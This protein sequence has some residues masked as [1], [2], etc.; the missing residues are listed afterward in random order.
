MKLLKKILP[1]ML[2]IALG[3]FFGYIRYPYVN[4]KGFVFGVLF[5]SI[6]LLVYRLSSSF[7]RLNRKGPK[8]IPLLY[9]L[10]AIVICYLAFSNKR[11]RN[12]N[13]KLQSEIITEVEEQKTENIEA[14]RSM[15]RLCI[16]QAKKEIEQHPERKL[17]SERIKEIIAI[18]RMIPVRSD[19]MGKGKAFPKSSK[20]RALFFLAL[21]SLRMNSSSFFTIKRKG[22]FEYADFRGD[23]NLLDSID[24]SYARLSGALFSN[25]SLKGSVFDHAELT[26]AKFDGVQAQGS[27]FKIAK[28][29]QSTLNKAN[30]TEADFSLANLSGSELNEV[31]LIEANM[32]YVSME[33][34]SMMNSLLMNTNLHGAKIKGTDLSKSNLSHADLS[35]SNLIK[36]KFNKAIMDSVNLDQAKVLEDFDKQLKK[37]KVSA[38]KTLMQDFEIREIRKGDKSKYIIS[39]KS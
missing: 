10:L 5:A 35:E 7:D 23:E 21:N 38:Y 2:L 19:M 33:W 13:A 39:K 30:F 28:I 3:W 14:V 1:A 26:F 15:Y 25:C 22:N 29:D 32:S 24:F 11:L 34:S 27:S 9:V 16:D 36:V 20:E 8:Y 6:L 37:A 4:M 31:Q 17:S 12:K 18:S